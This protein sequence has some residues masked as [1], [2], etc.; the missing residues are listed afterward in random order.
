MSSTARQATG[1]RI[2]GLRANALAGLTML[3]IEYSLGISANLYSTLPA[4]DKGKT[5]FAGLGAAVG[6]GPL[7]VS[8]HA[9]L[10]TLLLITGIAASVRASRLGRRPLIALSGTALLATLVAWLSGAAFVGHQKAAASLAM[11]IAAAVAILCYALVI[12]ILSPERMASPASQE[13][14]THV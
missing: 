12:F 2:R 13:Q 10:G 11:A 3:L 4:A 14:A 6:N 9:L 7:L 8:L 5:L 1:S